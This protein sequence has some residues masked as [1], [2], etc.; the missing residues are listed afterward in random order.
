ML[1][2]SKGVELFTLISYR[3]AV[4]FFSIRASSCMK[5]RFPMTFPRFQVALMNVKSQ[6]PEVAPHTP[7]QPGGYW[8]SLAPGHGAVASEKK[9]LGGNGVVGSQCW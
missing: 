5:C 4:F 2:A 7:K 3:G 8:W 1:L 9:I 6:T